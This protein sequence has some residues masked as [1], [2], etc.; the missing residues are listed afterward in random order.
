MHFLIEI[1]LFS[2]FAVPAIR[3]IGKRRT[4]TPRAAPE[5]RPSTPVSASLRR[6]PQDA[7]HTEKAAGPSQPVTPIR[8]RKYLLG[9]PRA[10][11]DTTAAM[12]D[13]MSGPGICTPRDH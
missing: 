5:R 1:V 11:R 4:I 12:L 10:E 13:M 7:E 3:L 6:V 8:H 9:S 2:L